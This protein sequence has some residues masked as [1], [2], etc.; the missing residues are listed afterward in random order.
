MTNGRLLLWAAGAAVTVAAS[1]LLLVPAAAPPPRVPPSAA[2]ATLRPAPPPTLDVA[3]NRALFAEPDPAGSAPFA[4]ADA[5]ALVG[6]AGRLPDDIVAL[7]RIDG[8][9]TRSLR[10]GDGI[11]G[12]R[13]SAIAADAAFFT[14]GG[15]QVRATLAP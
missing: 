9:R 6:I 14:R 3:L 1:G 13:L 7:V 2:P 15:E 4:A 11:D 12:W 5:P 8:G 10:V